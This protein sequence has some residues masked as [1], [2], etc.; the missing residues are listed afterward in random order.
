MQILRDGDW[1]RASDL[2]QA[3]GVTERTIWRDMDRLRAAGHPVMGARGTG[4]RIAADVTLP[5][6][7]LS[8]DELEALHI[9]LAIIGEG[10]EEDLARA[11][12]SLSEK[13]DA[14]LSEDATTGA[15]R[16]G[17]A[18]PPHAGPEPALAHLGPIRAALRARQKLRASLPDGDHVLRPL[19]LDYWGRVWA[20]TAWDETTSGFTTLR[21]D[22][23]RSVAAL[24]GLFV[25][26]PGKSLS[27][28]P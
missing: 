17:H 22:H 14:G 9:A 6:L 15:A 20:L 25:D 12:R 13:I 19:K 27:D 2:A 1:H 4:Y 24:P 5:P 8:H 21:L 7:N 28:L 16:F 11:A 18:L 3:T 23:I 26:E 10:G